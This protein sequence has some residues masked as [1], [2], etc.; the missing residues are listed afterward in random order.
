MLHG[1]LLIALFACAAFYIGGMDCVKALSFSPM[2]VG[3]II[4]MLYANS[5]RNNLPDTW[6]PGIKFCSK[7]ILRTGIIL[8]GFKLTFQDVMAV[9]FSAIVMDAIIVCGTIG[10]GIL[11]GRLL[12]IDRSIALLTACGSAICGAAAVLGID[13]AIRPKPYKTAVAVATVVIFGTLSMFL[14]PIL[15]RAG[16]FD[17]SPDMMG[18]FTVPPFM[19]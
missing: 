3:I 18:L 1:V 16:I 13:G 6:V 17:L 10:L 11:V 9:G 7:R 15:Y 4:G 14:Y 5:L 19:K 2:V 12:K 8:Y